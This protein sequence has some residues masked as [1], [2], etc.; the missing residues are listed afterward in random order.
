[1]R[2]VV[3]LYKKGIMGIFELLEIEN[4]NGI[5]SYEFYCLYM[6]I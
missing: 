5:N 1:M 6:Y 4:K 3:L 2:I